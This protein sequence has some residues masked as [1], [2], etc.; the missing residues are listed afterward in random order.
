MLFS[1]KMF[2]YNLLQFSR[3]DS[4]Y[5]KNK[6]NFSNHR[7]DCSGWALYFYYRLCSFCQ[8][9]FYEHAHDIYLCFCDHPCFDLG[10]QLYLQTDQK[11]SEEKDT[12]AH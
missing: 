6:T 5:E 2:T 12:T 8:R 10:I 9:K 7:R 3:K 11:D 4:K 1:D